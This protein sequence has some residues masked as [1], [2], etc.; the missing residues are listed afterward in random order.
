MNRVAG[1]ATGC[2]RARR[3]FCMTTVKQFALTRRS[4]RTLHSERAP[5]ARAGFVQ[6][7]SAALGSGLLQAPHFGFWLLFHRSHTKSTASSCTA[8]C[9]VCN[10][11]HFCSCTTSSNELPHLLLSSRARCALV[12]GIRCWLE[13]SSHVLFIFIFDRFSK[14]FR[15]YTVV[16]FLKLIIITLTPNTCSGN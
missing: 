1:K 7:L 10:S 13:T 9:F 12:H 6:S 4:R 16:L 14:D 8:C 5:Y 3:T 15:C 11:V 2:A